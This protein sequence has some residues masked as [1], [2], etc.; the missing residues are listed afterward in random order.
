MFT[1]QTVIDTLEFL[2]QN[3][4]EN[5]TIGEKSKG[6]CRIVITFEVLYQ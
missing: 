6:K 4:I 3:Q 1:L 5:K 2:I